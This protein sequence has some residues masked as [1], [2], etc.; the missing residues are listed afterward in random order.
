MSDTKA[1]TA[2]LEEHTRSDAAVLAY[3]PHGCKVVS[4]KRHGDSFWGWTGRIDASLDDGSEK[5]YFIKVQS[6]E[7]GNAMLEGEYE[8]MQAIRQVIPDF[9]PSIIGHG[10]YTS[11]YETP[12]LLLDFR[13]MLLELPAPDDFAAHLADLHSRST[14]PNSKFGFHVTTYPGNLP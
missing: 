6:G 1:S 5:C 7:R 2:E 11:L 14:S 12:F 4:V 9:A 10:T 8:S 3:L 13:D